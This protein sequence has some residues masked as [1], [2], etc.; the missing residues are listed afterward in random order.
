MSMTFVGAATR[1]GGRQPHDGGAQPALTH[2]W[3]RHATPRPDGARPFQGTVGTA[4]QLRSWLSALLRIG[5]DGDSK[6]KVAAWDTARHLIKGLE[7]HPHSV[8]G[9]M[10]ELPGSSWP[11]PLQVC[12]LLS[13]LLQQDKLDMYACNGACQRLFHSTTPRPP[14]PR[15][16]DGIFVKA[17]S[18]RPGPLDPTIPGLSC[19]V[20]PMPARLLPLPSMSFACRASH[21]NS[22]R[23][24]GKIKGE[25]KGL[26][27]YSCHPSTGPP[28]SLSSTATP[29]PRCPCSRCSSAAASTAPTRSS[30]SASS[31]PRPGCGWPGSTRAAAAPPPTAAPW[32]P[33]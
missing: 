11:R 3:G 24:R 16:I 6:K 22:N 33:A 8:D 18:S 13:P 12:P 19:P 9:R 32:G 5:A 23:I 21:I 17:S 26:S 15:P 20:R 27:K 1:R 10:D 4:A 29:A 30:R 14:R 2:V 25:R 7:Y 31:G 28:P